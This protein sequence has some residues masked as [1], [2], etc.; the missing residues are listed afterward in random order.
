[1]LPQEG[2]NAVRV[3]VALL[4]GGDYAELETLTEGCR[5]SASDMAGAIEGHGLDLISPP[6]EAFRDIGVTGAEQTETA[7]GGRAF[8]VAFPLWTAQEG[9]SAL[10]LRL[11]LSEVM[12]GVWT[13]ELDGIGAP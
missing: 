6:E 10:R 11:T 1:M 8:R 9:R 7:E 4:V 12:D 2:V 3:V 13:V 5:L